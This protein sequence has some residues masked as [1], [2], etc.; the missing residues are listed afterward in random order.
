MRLISWAIILFLVI[1]IG[2]RLFISPMSI[3]G[4]L[5]LA[6]AVYYLYR[7]PPGWLLRMGGFSTS[8]QAPKKQKKNPF[9][10][11]PGKK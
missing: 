10:V 1:G 11:I 2:H 3:F 9:K 6:G 5:L 8:K 4:P 7:F